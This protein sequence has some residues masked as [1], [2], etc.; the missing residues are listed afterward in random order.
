[1]EVKSCTFVA[2]GYDAERNCKVGILK[3]WKKK[4]IRAKIEIE[5]VTDESIIK[6]FAKITG[7]SKLACKHCHGERDLSNFV[8][9]IRRTIKRKGLSKD[10]VLPKT[11]D[12]QS[13][14]N[15]KRGDYYRALEK[16]KSLEEKEE[17][18]SHYSYAFNA[19]RKQYTRQE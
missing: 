15:K 3:I 2:L 4:A 9:V 1:M 12:H 7:R 5:K 19:E 16:A 14:N 6:V 11:C 10:M 8:N 18:K 17:L 13:G